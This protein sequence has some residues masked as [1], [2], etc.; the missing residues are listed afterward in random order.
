MSKAL[1]TILL[2]A[3]T[4]SSSTLGA[5]VP[6]LVYDLNPGSSSPGSLTS[7]DNKLYFVATGGNTGR[8]LWSYDGSSAAPQLVADMY[9]GLMGV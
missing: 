2:L 8:E 3:G 4:I 9:P 7:L 1:Y 5:Q 6:K